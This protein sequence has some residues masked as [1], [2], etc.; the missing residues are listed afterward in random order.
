MEESKLNAKQLKVV[1]FLRAHKGE[2]LTL[3]EIK[4]GAK[5]DSLKT[6]TTNTL[7]GKYITCNKDARVVVCKCCGH[8]TKVS[9]YGAI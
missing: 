8:K 6:G 7:I 5:L 2:E 3:N 9:T 1:E 4:Q